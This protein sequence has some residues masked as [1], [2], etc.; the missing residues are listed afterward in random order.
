LKA[1]FFRTPGEFRAWLK[2]NHASV[3]ELLVGYHKVDSGRPSMTWPESVDQ[4]LC[5]GWIDGVRR[6]I[7]DESYSIRFSPRK[8]VSTWSA[9]N[10]RRARA[11]IGE[12]AMQPAG[13]RAFEAR[14]EDRSGT[15]SYE[16]RRVELDEPYRGRL[17]RNNAAYQFF[18]D[19]P[20]AYKR[21]VYSWIMSAKKDETRLKRFA[22]LIE[23]ST[24]G[25]RIPEFTRWERPKGATRQT[26]SR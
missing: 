9:V 3:A 20:D 15:Y 13:L 14:R 18:R 1:K 10:I 4:A 8:P 21:T 6:R 26:A 2:K 24:E 22:R 19:Q 23:C 7:D 25:Q 5:F 17:K 11:L 16:Q 12:G